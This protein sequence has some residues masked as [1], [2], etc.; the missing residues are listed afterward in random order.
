MFAPI[1]G[2]V[3]SI[4]CF[5]ITF[6][7][8]AIKNTDVQ[9]VTRGQEAI[10]TLEQMHIKGSYT[11]QTFSC[12]EFSS[13]ANPQIA[14]DI[15]G[16]FVDNTIYC[17]F[18]QNMDLSSLKLNAIATDGSNVIYNGSVL[19]EKSKIDISNG[20][21]IICNG[22][23]FNI[24]PIKTELPYISIVTMN[25]NLVYPN[26]GYVISAGRL[27]DVQ[28]KELFSQ[29]MQIRVRGNLTSTVPKLSYKIKTD[30]SFSLLGLKR[31]D[32]WTLMANFFDPSMLRNQLAYK[33][34]EFLEM[35]Y[36]PQ[37]QYI[38]LY[39][40]GEYQ[41][42]YALGTQV[43]LNSGNIDIEPMGI[44][45]NDGSYLLELDW[46]SRGLQSNFKSM[47]DLVITL[48]EPSY[49]TD[50][51][52]DIIQN[53]VSNF[54]QAILSN[55]FTYNGVHY[56]ELINVESFAK[57]YLV[58]EIL[59]NPDSLSALS[60]YIYRQEDGKLAM[61][62]IW[63]FD[64]C[65]GNNS[66]DN[67]QPEGL[68]LK[69]C[70]WFKQLLSD[71]YFFSI[72]KEEYKKLSGYMNWLKDYKIQYELQMEKAL[73]NNFISTYIGVN[74]YSNTPYDDPQKEELNNLLN[75]ITRRFQWL[76]N[77]ECLS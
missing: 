26:G 5:R 22:Q 9:N 42:V 6:L 12:F 19:T 68:Y 13:A 37:Q 44:D 63:D 7:Y 34:A 28:G 24:V 39:L 64:L 14:F 60:I 36:V 25:D 32:S 43:G 66:A 75:W 72:V 1:L 50:V 30:N 23:V 58:N 67:S 74:S 20:A 59:S 38:E 16:Y 33:M 8:G 54:E 27:F 51:Q 15:K 21:E 4:I 69:D 11:S 70:Y 55:D 3:L 31:A 61:G 48:K 57:C 77:N 45:G 49:I 10:N 2:L 62:P 18:P 41:G 40:N 73:N 47:F 52:R 17:F 56:S 65:A 46:R 71:P 29:L 76:E 35:E 53:E